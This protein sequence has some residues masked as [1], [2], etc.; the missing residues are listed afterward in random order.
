LPA[1]WAKTWIVAADGSGDYT[2][3]QDAV[4]AASSGDLIIIRP[5]YYYQ[6]F[7]ITSK[8]LTIVGSG[9]GTTFVDNDNYSGGSVAFVDYIPA[10]GRVIL[11]HMTLRSFACLAVY[12]VSTKEGAVVSQVELRRAPNGGFPGLGL[13]LAGIRAAGCRCPLV[14]EYE[15][16]AWTYGRPHG[17][18]FLNGI[19]ALSQSSYTGLKGESGGSG[20]PPKQGGAGVYCENSALYLSDGSG[21]GGLGGEAYLDGPYCDLYWSARPG[22][23]GLEA[24]K[25][26]VVITAAS[27]P[28]TYLGGEGGSGKITTGCGYPSY[29]GGDGGPGVFTDSS[30]FAMLVGPITPVGGPGGEGSPTGDP[31]PATS[32]NVTV[33]SDPW[34]SLTIGGSGAIA[35]PL[36]LSAKAQPGDR[37]LMIAADRFDRLTV[38]G[39][40][41]FPLFAVPGG[42]FFFVMPIGSVGPTGEVDVTLNIPDN[43]AAIG[44]VAVFQVLAMPSQG[45][46]K[47]SNM[48]LEVLRDK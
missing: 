9:I 6:H 21:T 32:G 43:P 35:A 38:A 11:A 1:G 12:G 20:Y 3:I 10:N 22:G 31:G 44:Q 27:A 14:N 18:G 36:T 26:S 46:P 41:G 23:P 45:L 39:I 7:K 2:K 19:F 4:D 34:P 5:G 42:T 40:G 37:L 33:E 15:D 29:K 28:L 30:S 24:D 13:T 48:V 8:E 17:S 16:D 47:L 25:G